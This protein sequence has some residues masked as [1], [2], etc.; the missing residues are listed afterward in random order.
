MNLSQNQPLF[1]AL[2][3]NE[4]EKLWARRGKSLIIAL[5]L[6]VA[7]ATLLAQHN[8]Q[9][10]LTQTQANIG[11][12][13]QQVAQIRNLLAKAPANQKAQLTQQ[14]Q[15]AESALQQDLPQG[16]K[17]E[18]ASLAS[19]VKTSAPSQKGTMLEQLALARYRLHHDVVGYAQANG[20]FRQPGL[21]FSGEAILL[22]A[23]M[24]VAVASD[25][26]SGELEGGTWGMLLLHAP[27]RGRVYF[28]KFSAAL[29]VVW[30]FMVAAAIGLFGFGGLLMGFGS[31]NAPHAVGVKI[32]AFHEP[33]YTQVLPAIQAFHL[34]PQWSYDLMALG[35]AMLALGGFVSLLI[36]LSILTR[37]T[38]LSLVIGVVMVLSG[39]FVAHLLGS[40]GVFDPALHFPLIADWTGS[41]ATQ[42]TL[43]SLS[44]G[45]GLAVT[46]VWALAAIIVGVWTIRRLDV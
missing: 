41:L 25:I 44:L 22:F 9:Q 45:M 21:I 7:G 31:A 17:A 5:I 29:S 37:S 34:V 30:A 24:A 26:F 6:I 16:S 8:E 42:N 20:G 40:L 13:R 11:G 23:L 14:L 15:F 38:V 27:R 2:F 39:V 36:A 35:L 3:H 32:T 4:I 46:L 33:G 18:I 12:A 10:Y 43:P 28:A 19:A 1:W